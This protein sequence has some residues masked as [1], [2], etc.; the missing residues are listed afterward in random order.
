[1]LYDYTGYAWQLIMLIMHTQDYKDNTT[2]LAA[3][4]NVC[5]G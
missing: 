5:V 3:A 4:Q 1:M 2:A